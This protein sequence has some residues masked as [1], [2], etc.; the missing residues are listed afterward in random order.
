MSDPAERK[1]SYPDLLAA[2]DDERSRVRPRTPDTPSGEERK[3]GV[4][5][6]PASGSSPAPS[7]SQRLEHK[8]RLATALLEKLPANDPR[9][10]ML[11]VAVLRRDEALLDGVLSELNARPGKIG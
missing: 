9:A 8:V 3:A 10:R 1:Q 5:G 11:H 4:S 7:L 6:P 2:Q